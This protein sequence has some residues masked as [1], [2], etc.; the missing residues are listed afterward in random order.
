MT[1]L[2]C[3]TAGD[4]G[5]P[6][7]M[8]LHGF[9]SCNSQ[10]LLNRE[11]LAREHYLLMVELWGHGDSPAPEDPACFSV[12]AYTAQFEEIRRAQGINQWAVIGQSYGA[13]LVIQYALQH[14]GVCTRVVVT[15]SRSAF[16]PPT[17]DADRRDPA[18]DSTVQ[19]RQLPYHPIH[20]RRFPPHVQQALVEKADAMQ[21]HS[22][23][24]GGRL[25]ADLNCRDKLANLQQ[26]LLL[27]NGRYEK[28]FQTDLQALLQTCPNLNVVHLDGGHS[29][30]IEAAE[31]FNRAV[32]EFLQAP[33]G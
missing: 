24:L 18:P 10:W 14:P 27:T 8:L 4:P 19:P 32:L 12:A 25:G 20:A 16:G 5:A 15:N 9:M 22:I 26:P 21:P 17:A 31:G 29:V 28:S 1:K 2:A 6:A 7:V 23:Q 33:A 30:N 3:T 11:A 13:G